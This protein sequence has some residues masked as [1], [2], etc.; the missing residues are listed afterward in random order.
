MTAR[1]ERASR[2]AP[3]VP[4]GVW[5]AASYVLGREISIEGRYPHVCYWTVTGLVT[6]RLVYL[7]SGDCPACLRQRAGRRRDA[8]GI[9]AP[10]G[11][12]QALAAGEEDA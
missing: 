4:V 6:G 8:P 12:T 7:T 1:I 10:R 3:D 5:L 9:P 2:A 11:D